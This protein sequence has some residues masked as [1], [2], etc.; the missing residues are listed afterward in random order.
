[1][2]SSYGGIA[3]AGSPGSYTYS[4]IAGRQDM[5][6]NYVSFYNSL[7]FANWLHSGQPSGAQDGTTTEDGAYDMSLGSNVVRKAGAKVF[8]TSE[9]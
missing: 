6:V 8:L 5:P 2:G 9:A 3:R 1:M 7:R 4:P